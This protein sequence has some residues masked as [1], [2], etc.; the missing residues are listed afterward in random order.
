MTTKAVT[1]YDK[2]G[3]NATIAQLCLQGM[4]QR[5]I[6]KK[7]GISKSQVSRVLSSNKWAKKVLEAAHNAML[8][9]SVAVALKLNEHVQN[10]DP[11]ISLKAIQQH[12]TNMGF[13]PSHT[14]N[15]FIQNIYNGNQT[16]ILNPTIEKMISGDN[17]DSSNDDDIIDGEL[18][19][20]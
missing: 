10:S 5:Q 17:T 13:R 11:A 14:Q 15:T 16:N 7:I 12:Q 3:R 19:D 8:G 9:E 1:R 6:A 4:P 18:I 20:D 2:S